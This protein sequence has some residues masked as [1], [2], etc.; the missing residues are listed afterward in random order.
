MQDPAIARL[1][2]ARDLF[3]SGLEAVK[4]NRQSSEQS[5]QDRPQYSINNGL[6]LSEKHYAQFM[7]MLH[8]NLWE[9]YESTNIPNGKMIDMGDALVYTDTAGNIKYAVEILDDVNEFASLIIEYIKD[10]MFEGADFDETRQIIEDHFG[11]RSALFFSQRSYQ[12]DKGQITRRTTKNQGR[13]GERSG[14]SFSVSTGEENGEVEYSLPV[15]SETDANYMAAVETGDMDAAQRMVDEAA[16]SVMKDSKIRDE[17]GKLMTVYHG[18]EESFTVFDPAKGRA[19]MGIQGM[20]F[21]PWVEEA[22]GYGGKVGSYYLDIKNPAPESVGYAA[23]R[24]YQGQN[25]A[26][27]KAREYLFSQGYDGVNNEDQEY[28]AFYPEQ[29]KSVDPVTY[30]D[31]GNIIPPERA[32]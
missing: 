11:E 13:K 21:S 6:P 31:A 32:L 26:G 7:E 9:R 29:I 10:E 14:N 1:E 30:D 18:T 25:G 4:G 20:F 24:K 3:E 5:E 22:A 8:Y 28:I 17:D 19:N 27:A 16:E 12:T 23:L 2:K 15:S